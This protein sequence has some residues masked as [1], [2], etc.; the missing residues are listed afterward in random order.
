MCVLIEGCVEI[1]LCHWRNH[2][3]RALY[4]RNL[5]Q[6]DPGCLSRASSADCDGSTCRPPASHWSFLCE[7]PNNRSVQHGFSPEIRR[8]LH[9]LQQQGYFLNLK[10]SGCTWWKPALFCLCWCEICATTLPHLG[11]P[12]FH[13]MKRGLNGLATWKHFSVKLILGLQQ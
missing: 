3:P 1:C 4:S 10:Y 12:F 9:S 5:H 2:L 11:L 8:Y 13:D 7:Y 6:S